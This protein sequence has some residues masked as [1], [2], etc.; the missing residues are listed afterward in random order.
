MKSIP[1]QLYYFMR[2]GPGRVNLLSL[3]RFLLVLA[4]LITFY[5]ILFHY[6]ME[7]EGRQY[8]WVTGFYW[9][10]TV[11]STLG[12]GDITFE[13]D[14]G[15]IFSSI[16]L[17]SGILFLLILFPFTFIEFFY[18]PWVKAQAASRAPRELPAQTRGH[19]VITNRDSVT[20]ALIHKL[21]QYQYPYVLLQPD[22]NETLHLHDLGYSVVWGDVDDPETYRRIQVNQASL[23]VSTATDMVNTNVAFTVR[24]ISEKVPIITTANVSASVDI[25][26]LAG[27]N[28]VLQL[29]HLMGQALARRITGG[30]TQAYVIGEIDDL[31]IAEALVGRNSLAGKTIR[32]SALRQQ[33]GVTVLGVWRRG[34]YENAGPDTVLEPGMILLLAGSVGCFT[35]YNE[36]VAHEPQNDA[37]VVII[38]GGR[39]GRA[40]AVSL[41]TRG[42]EYRLVEK[43]PER[44]RDPQRYILGDAA[45]LTVLQ[46]AGIMKANTAVITTHD[47]DINIYLTIYC[48]RLRPDLQ[49]I[50][51]A[52]LERNVATLHRA[53]ADFVLSYASM[54]TNY[55]MNILNR[56]T[57]FMIAEGLDV[58]KLHVPKSL[59][60]RTLAQANV[61]QE[62]E[63]NIVALHTPDGHTH[64]NP[65]PNL[66]LPASAELVIIGTTAAEQRFLQKFG[67]Q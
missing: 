7:Y 58:F 43:Q 14:L 21:Q 42:M 5:S 59:A 3:I 2:R 31:Q 32:E 24:E 33:Y 4:A 16:V 8:S 10:L 66:P 36:L 34:Q 40:T 22:L 48:R 30:G 44:I 20:E 6:L 12:F 18:A 11:M 46:E 60:G 23:V 61:R 26:E 57:I 50:T 37:P 65:D 19:V 9:T 62:T 56:S 35:R 45:E 47:D 27:S 52:V 54:G 53:G 63:C 17:F 1:S 15:R 51:R 25:L 39:V 49:I 29:G 55:I 13:S 38:G 67:S 64:I 41:L 28:H